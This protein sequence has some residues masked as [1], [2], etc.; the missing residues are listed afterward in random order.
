MNDVWGKLPPAYGTFP[1]K[2]FAKNAQPAQYGTMQYFMLPF[3]EQDNVYKSIQGASYKSGPFVIKT[4]IAPNDPSVPPGGSGA[5]NGNRGVC[6]Y[7]CNTYVFG[8]G[9]SGPGPQ[10]EMGPQGADGGYANIPRTFLDGT[11]NTIVFMEY[12]AV[13]GSR[14]VLWSECEK[15]ANA[16]AW[17]NTLGGQPPT[18]MPPQTVPPTFKNDWKTPLP[19]VMPAPNQCDAKL[20]QGFSKSG[21]MVGMGDGSSRLIKSSITAPTWTYAIFPNDGMV[22]GNDW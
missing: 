11:S 3:I 1:A 18:G 12:Y 10:T 19:Q 20:A 7:A 16:P 2:G 8:T 9:I 4:F 17:P 22:L 21:I 14:T 5:A 15:P 13:C 6:S